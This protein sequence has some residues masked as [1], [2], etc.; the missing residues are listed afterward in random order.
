MATPAVDRSIQSN[1]LAWMPAYPRQSGFEKATT[2]RARILNVGALLLPAISF[3]ELSIGGRLLITELVLM[4]ALPWLLRVPERLS[5]PRWFIVFW[6]GW[7][8]SQMLTDVIVGSAFADYTRGWAK[9][10][11]T[12]T[13]F[14]AVAAL[15]AT[16]TRARLFAIG[17]AIAGVGAYVVSPELFPVGD[18]W[19]WGF[20]MP[21][22]LVIAAALA[23]ERGGR[24]P[25]LP[26]I[27]FAL[28]GALN[29]LMGYRSLGGVALVAAGYFV[30]NGIVGSP[31]LTLRPSIPRALV[32][33]I[34]GLI[35]ALG[36]L[37]IYDAAAASGQLG[38]EAQSKYDKQ[39]GSFGVLLGGRSEALGSTQAVLDSP[40]LGHGSWA[41]D[42]K[43]V[44]LL[45]D[46]LRELGYG[47]HDLAQIYEEGLIPTHSYLL[48]AWVE[49]GFLGA[50]FWLV[51]GLVAVWLLLNLYATR[52]AIA[53]LLVFVSALLLWSIAFSPY[54]NSARLTAAYAIA[55]CLLGLRAMRRDEPDALRNATEP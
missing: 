27:A 16:P 29:L 25:W 55:L 48:G 7:L 14:V 51:V 45:E 4:A 26:A 41:K 47:D 1:R 11:F 6:G 30:L 32:G 50:L 49:A 21:I 31:S 9:I 43:Y 34:F 13:N 36:V 53:P 46:R 39:S 35:L 42:F 5:I 44:D 15:V 33:T 17:L 38:R 28:F 2:R 40:I 54:A 24:H 3:I 18:P 23:G 8:I 10:A 12:L 52:L 19:K 20:A 22:G 37:S